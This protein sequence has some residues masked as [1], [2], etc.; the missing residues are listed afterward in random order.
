MQSI[1]VMKLHVTVCQT[2]IH[3]IFPNSFFSHGMSGQPVVQTVR[4]HLKAF[5]YPVSRR[6]PVDTR[7]VVWAENVTRLD[8]RTYIVQRS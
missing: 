6:Q 3:R 7:V 2:E 5:N 8:V 1:T 4:A